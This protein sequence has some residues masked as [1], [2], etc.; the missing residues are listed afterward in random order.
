MPVLLANQA[1]KQRT[2]ASAT[3]IVVVVMTKVDLETGDHGGV[4]PVARTF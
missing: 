2:S 1:T 3:T 4:C